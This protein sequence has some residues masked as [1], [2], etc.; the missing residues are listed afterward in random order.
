M[1]EPQQVHGILDVTRGHDRQ[2]H[3]AVVGG[4]DRVGAESASVD[5]DLAAN[6]L[7]E[8]SPQPVGC[9]GLHDGHTWSMP[10]LAS[11]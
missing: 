9:L 7:R 10:G 1:P 6:P 3:L 8:V 11:G 4:V 2:G 5:P